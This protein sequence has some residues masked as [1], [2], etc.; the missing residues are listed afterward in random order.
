MDY[1]EAYVRALVNG[2]EF[3]DADYWRVLGLLV[4][5]AADSA[6]EQF[7]KDRAEVLADMAAWANVER[8]A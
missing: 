3:P 6:S 4:G 2:G 7:G 5:T 1:R 8:G